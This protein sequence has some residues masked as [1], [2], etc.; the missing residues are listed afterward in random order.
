VIRLA[1]LGAFLVLAAARVAGAQ[2]DD[3]SMPA[4]SVLPNYDRVSIGHREGLEANAYPARADDAAASWFNPP[5]CPSAK[6]AG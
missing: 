1:G 5:A 4:G 3:F 2:T 6:R